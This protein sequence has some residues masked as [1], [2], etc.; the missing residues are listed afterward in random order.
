MM[1]YLVVAIVAIAL[2]TGNYHMLYVLGI[3]LA[4][5]YFVFRRFQ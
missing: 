1:R 5:Q 3:S 4:I 2:L